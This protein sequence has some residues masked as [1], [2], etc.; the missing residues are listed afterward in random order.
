M[1]PS[2]FVIMDKLPVTLNGKLDRKTLPAPDFAAAT[3]KSSRDP[4]NQREELLCQVFAELLEVPSV[5]VDDSFFD[6]GG[7]SL[8][9]TRLV[10]R[11]RAVL[12]TEVSIRTVFQH[13]TVAGIA[14]R[15]EGNSPARASS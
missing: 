4:V 14:P 9:A 3:V 2:A 13:P 7:H 5:G 6:L 12:K 8:L 15:L 10:S 11:I 1:I